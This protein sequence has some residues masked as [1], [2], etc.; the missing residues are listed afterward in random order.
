MVAKVGAVLAHV[1]EGLKVR[2]ADAGGLVVTGAAAVF[3]SLN[4]D[5]MPGY[6]SG[7]GLHVSSGRVHIVAGRFLADE[8]RR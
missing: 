3:Q 8:V 2:A 1:P 7:L 4:G 5:A 6:A